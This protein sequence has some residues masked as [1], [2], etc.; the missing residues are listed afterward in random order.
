MTPL[1]SATLRA[2]LA[3]A[4]L[5]PCLL[6]GSANVDGSAIFAPDREFGE[7]LGVPAGK[8][9]VFFYGL[10]DACFARPDACKAVETEILVHQGRRP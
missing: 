4:L 7:R 2:G 10:C 9:R 8:T 5:Q 6:C 1:T 3:M